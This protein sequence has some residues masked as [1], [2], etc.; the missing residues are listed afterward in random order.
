MLEIGEF[1]APMPQEGIAVDFAPHDR[2]TWLVFETTSKTT[3]HL[4]GSHSIAIESNIATCISH[5]QA[6]HIP[7]NAAQVWTLGG[8]IAMS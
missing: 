3:Q 1:D 5:F 4:L 8:I 6:R 7:F 2:V